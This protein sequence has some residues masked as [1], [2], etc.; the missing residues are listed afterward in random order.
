[1]TDKDRINEKDLISR[2]KSGD[3]KAFEEIIQM[4][5]KKICTTISYMI[6]DKDSVEDVAQEVFIKVYSNLKKFNEQSSLFTWIYRITMNACYDEIKREKKIS[7]FRNYVEEDG[8]EEEIEREDPSQDV[9]EI[10]ESRLNRAK[11]I[12]TLKRLPKEQRALI[13]LR[14]IRGFSY[15]EI[16]DMLKL[17]LG[18][19]KSQISRARQKLKDELEASGLGDFN[20]DDSNQF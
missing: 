2:A 6:K 15:W 8:E 11:L 3:D 7:F 17:K 10:V 13:V 18:T 4:Y 5:Q 20:I 9:H 12:A 14:D 1:M 19:V 16:A